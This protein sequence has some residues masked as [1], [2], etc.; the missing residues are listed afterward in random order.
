MNARGYAPMR[1]GEIV[2]DILLHSR[3]SG[4]WPEGSQGEWMAAIAKGVADKLFL[5]VDG[6]VKLAPTPASDGTN[7]SA[8]QLELF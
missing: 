6:K 1:D 8:K 7:D 5:I 3:T 4:L 2:A